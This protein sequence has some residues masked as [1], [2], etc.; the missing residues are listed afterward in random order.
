LIQSDPLLESIQY[1]ILVFSVL[2]FKVIQSDTHTQVD[3]QVL[4][5]IQCQRESSL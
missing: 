5:F 3:Q 4:R 2:I 1:K